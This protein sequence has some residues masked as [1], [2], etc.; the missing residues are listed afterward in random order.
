MLHVF[1]P[2][3]FTLAGISEALHLKLLTLLAS[4]CIK[5]AKL[6]AYAGLCNII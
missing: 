6:N 5:C 2:E 4:T 1:F 3:G